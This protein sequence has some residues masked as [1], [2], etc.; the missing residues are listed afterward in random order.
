MVRSGRESSRFETM[1]FKPCGR[2]TTASA[3]IRKDSAWKRLAASTI[4]GN[5]LDAFTAYHE[6]ES[7]VDLGGRVALDGRHGSINLVGL[8]SAILRNN[9]QGR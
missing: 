7:P 1:P 4:A 3:S 9:I 2:Q 6:P 5:P 8:R